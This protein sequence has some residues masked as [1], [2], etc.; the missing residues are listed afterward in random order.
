ATRMSG[1]SYPPPEV[2]QVSKEGT[3]KRWF[4][5][6]S[7]AL[8]VWLGWSFAQGSD[9]AE[10]PNADRGREAVRGRPALNPAFW[11]AAAYET[12]WKAWGLKEK[13]V[14][15]DAAFRARYGLHAAPYENGGL[16]MGLHVAP[17]PLG[18]G[19][20]SDCLLCHAGSVAGKTYLGL[21]NAS[22]DFQTLFDELSATAVLPR[23]PVQVGKV[24]GTLE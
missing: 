13:P 24:R 19:L 14:N 9:R 20:G 18:K 17:G 22:L 7:L 1:T 5:L 16:P 4:P 11:S 15:H 3:M 21:G 23:L 2:V 8:L 6:G 10:K 12:A